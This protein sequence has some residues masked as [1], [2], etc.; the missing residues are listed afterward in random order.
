MLGQTGATYLGL[1]DKGRVIKGLVVCFVVDERNN[2]RLQ[3]VEI[4]ISSTTHGLSIN[5]FQSWFLSAAEIVLKIMQ[6]LLTLAF[7]S[8]KKR[9]TTC[10]CEHAL[11]KNIIFHQFSSAHFCFH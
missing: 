8:L 7:F 6:P 5:F 2:F 1:P 10:V 4:W 11:E 9:S 3:I